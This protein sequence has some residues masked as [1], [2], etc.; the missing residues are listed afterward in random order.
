MAT[1][2]ICVICGKPATVRNRTTKTCSEECSRVNRRINRGGGHYKAEKTE[3]GIGT[4]TACAYC[5]KVF[6]RRSK[7]Q[8]F[9]G[10]ACSA[11]SATRIQKNYGT[12]HCK[13]CGAE[14]TK[15][16]GNQRYCSDGCK[17]KARKAQEAEWRMTHKTVC[18]PKVE[19]EKPE[20]VKH[21]DTT[22]EILAEARKRGISYG[23]M[24]GMRY[25]NLI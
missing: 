10:V 23:K 17:E 22:A 6:T 1:D 11:H 20:P 2:I 18:V 15:T 19:E 16:S 13:L 3:D 5:G 9:C 4:V 25:M 12:D 14:Y 7:G 21:I 8:K 24:Q